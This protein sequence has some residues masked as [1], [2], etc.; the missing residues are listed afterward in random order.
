MGTQTT[1]SRSRKKLFNR[2]AFLSRLHESSSHV[3]CYREAVQQTRQILDKRFI[4]K[5]PIENIIS[6]QSWFVDQLLITAWHQFG[7]KD[8]DDISLIAVGGY[9]RGELHPYSDIDIQILLAK[10]NKKKYQKDIEQFLTF[11]WDINLE[12]GQSVRSIKENQQE[13]ARDI[14]IATSLIES[15]TLAGNS[16]L[17]EKSS[18]SWA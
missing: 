6:D 17:L 10:N 3:S 4:Q 8:A 11:L 16:E 13:A 5:S 14:T 12:I 15:R 18:N 2:E 9:G 1:I 7:W